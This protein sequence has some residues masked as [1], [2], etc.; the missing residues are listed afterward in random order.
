MGRIYDLTCPMLLALAV[1]ILSAP[2][3]AE[4]VVL[5]VYMKAWHSSERFDPGRGSVLSW[6]V[7]MTRSAALDRLRSRA[8]K[9]GRSTDPLQ[10]MLLADQGR[11]PESLSIE[12]QRRARVVAA[13]SELPAEQRQAIEIAYFEGLTHSELAERLSL[14]LGTVKTRVRYGLKRLRHLLGDW[15]WSE[16]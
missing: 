7:V 16:I 9:Q 8:V 3:D 13:L 15:E 4:E 2:E 14:P 10:E 12:N 6:L 5:D 11:D 1:R